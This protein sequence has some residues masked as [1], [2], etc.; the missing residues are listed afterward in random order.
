M[1]GYINLSSLNTNNFRT[2]DKERSSIFLIQFKT[3]NNLFEMMKF[4]IISYYHTKNI[5]HARLSKIKIRNH[6]LNS[7]VKTE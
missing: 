1:V 7:K 2:D 3:K 4:W 5:A 6:S